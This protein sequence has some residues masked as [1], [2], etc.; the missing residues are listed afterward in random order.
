MIFLNAP[1]FIRFDKFCFMGYNNDSLF[2]GEVK[3]LI[4][5]KKRKLRVRKP[6]HSADLVQFQNRRLKSGRKKRVHIFASLR[7]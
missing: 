7:P 2:Q 3:L 5:G 6:N 4:G 1:Q